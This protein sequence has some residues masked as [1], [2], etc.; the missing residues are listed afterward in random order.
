MASSYVLLI[1]GFLPGILSQCSVEKAQ[2][3]LKRYVYEFAMELTTR[4]A[5]DQENHFIASTLSPWSILSCASYGADGETLRELKS[6]LK[7][8]SH[9]CYNDKYFELVK[10][11]TEGDSSVV[12][13]RSS[14]IFVDENLGVSEFFQ[15]AI[16]RIGISTIDTLS[17]EN[18][19]VAAGTIN[20]YVARATRKTILDV[21]V[22]SD[23]D[24]VRLVMVDAVYFKG[25][26]QIPFSYETTK[27]KPFF[28][29]R[30]AQIG[31][32]NMMWLTGVFNMSYVSLIDAKV[33]ELPYGP[34]GRYSMLV[35]LPSEGNLLSSMIESLT[36]I[37]LTTIYKIFARD[38][39]QSVNVEIPRFKIASD[40]NNLKDFL[41]D[42]GV[43]SAFDSTQAEFPMLSINPLYISNFVQKA[44]IEV[45]EE[46][47]IAS[48]ATELGFSAR[49]SPEIFK[50]N[51]PFFYM[52]VDT[53]TEI[54]LFTGAYSK[55]SLY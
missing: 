21:V 33:L 42:M 37:S 55:P 1:C 9:E 16:E 47:S 34:N 30:G 52:I 5:V 4:I 27:V 43:R 41:F 19:E 46:G 24:G 40:L 25:L 28:N 32:V 11:V 10:K 51:R 49:S 15:D 54:V 7:L 18:P 50:A 35:F 48:A 20:D 23:L 13:D 39:M 22:P 38:F 14:N 29:E 12:I 53:Q 31:D 36:H 3:L 6:V 17:F 8:H 45:N 2:P 26:W 44:N